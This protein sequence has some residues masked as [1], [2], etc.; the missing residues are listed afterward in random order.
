[1]EI[2]SHE[3]DISSG[4]YGA[5]NLFLTV[6][7]MCKMNPAAPSNEVSYTFSSLSILGSEIYERFKHSRI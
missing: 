7:D 1:M 2:I 6:F 3:V 5:W 4:D